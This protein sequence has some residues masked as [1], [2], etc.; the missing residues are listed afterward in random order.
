MT[1]PD[2]VSQRLARL[3][4]QQRAALRQRLGGRGQDRPEP[5]PPL[6]RRTGDRTVSRLGLD[7]ERI[8]ILDQLD[9]GRHTYNISAGM[10]FK[11]AFD[12]DAF[13]AAAE[14]VV[15]RHDLL[16]SSVE[17]HDG[18][19]LLRVHEDVGS[20]VRTFDLRAEPE[21]L[22]ETIRTLVRRP[23]DLASGGLLRIFVLRTA[24]DEYQIVETMHHSATDQWSYVRLNRE[25]LEHYRAALEGRPARVPELPVQ[26]GDFAEWQRD[27]FTGPH[28]DRCRRFWRDHLDGAP[29][30]LPL[31]YDASPAGA[32]HEGKHH[33]FLLDPDVSTAFLAACRKQR[34]TLS[35]ALLSAYVA[36][37]HEETGLHDIVVGLP[38]ATRGRPETSDLIG[39]LLT[40]VPVRARLPQ[41]PTPA[42][43]LAAVR[44]ASAAVADHRETPFSEIVEAASPERSL[45]HYPLLQTMHL[46][47]D[48]DDTVLEAPGAEVIGT[49][50]ED[51]VSPMDI[52][53]G[54]WRAGDRLYGRLEY[55]TEL[56]TDATVERLT[57]RLLTLVQLFTER[58]DE[59]LRVREAPRPAVTA[60]ATAPADRTAALPE[61]P[62]EE[63]R[64]LTAV[65]ADVLGT[66]VGPDDNF[67]HSGGTSLK[68]IQLS[69]A[70]RAAGFD[71]GPR[72][73][74]HAPTIRGQL[75]LARRDPGTPD[76]A[77][78]AVG[79]VSPQQEDLLEGGLPRTE[80]WSHS[81]VLTAARGLDPEWMKIVTKRVVAAHPGLCTVFH[82]HD[83]GWRAAPADRWLWRVEEP[84][85]APADVAA[86][87]REAFD[88]GDGPLFAVS[89]IP[90][91]PD[92]LVLTAHHLVVDGLSWHVLATELALAYRGERPV[93]E[94]RHPSAVAAAQ[95]ARDVRQ[96]LPYWREQLRDL[97]PLGCRT[98]GP[99]LIGAETAHRV[100][101]PLPPRDAGPGGAD[102]PGWYTEAL[103][104]VGRA[105]HPWFGGA[106]AVVDVIG[107]G[108]EL[109]PVAGWDPLR[110]VGFYA[111]V[112]PVRLPLGGD[113]A[114]H[115]HAV[116]RALDAVPEGGTGYLALRWSDDPEVRAEVAALGRPEVSFN[117]VGTLLSGAADGENRGDGE[118]LLAVEEQVGP[119][120]NAD[121]PRYHAVSV[122]CE[123]DAHEAAFTWKFSPD[124][125]D[126]DAVR[127]AAAVAAEEFGRL[128]RHRGSAP[129]TTAGMPLDA[130]N[131]MLAD[132]TRGRKDA[133]P[134]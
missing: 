32:G 49:E 105:V 31:P 85:T 13:R 42:Q 91:R 2:S 118:A 128:A 103:T 119:S 88:L 62:T 55:R 92:R 43:V 73:I 98:G 10:R 113:A 26:F 90:G 17:V 83:G 131:Q 101:V 123:T 77:A 126:A 44:E 76:D 120:G 79:A 72:Q 53:V 65:W 41:E 7:Q 97:K 134:V 70:L 108:R 78:H 39:F 111:T 15:R 50:V 52:T 20:P 82:R 122:V 68:V 109:P 35:D 80:L 23:F 132:L 48:F 107:P 54:W 75:G 9:P 86:A 69:H 27:R 74:F 22:H 125:V 93:P 3:T 121:A 4:P 116:G 45:D 63:L 24:D 30:R 16:R 25:L 124:A 5:E 61:P 95:R 133:R 47:L 56:F 12:E 1:S 38:S 29:E 58:P 64:T 84:D 96:Q 129:S 57:R 36:L 66:E 37:L 18:T 6:T 99:D 8:W 102:G 87:H 127:A 115:V 59:P 60:T 33:Y 114:S 104:A 46:V 71:I 81:L 28:R 40:N 89:L 112:H 11:G 67:F 94:E 117:H 100:R 51:G 34:V 110:S 130:V 19:P 21:R 106:D 14:A